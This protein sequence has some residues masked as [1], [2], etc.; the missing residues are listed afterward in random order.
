[1]L[2]TA[3]CV[4]A[5]LTAGITA[6]RLLDSPLRYDEADFGAQAKG[7]LAYGVPKVNENGSIR[8]GMWHPPLYLY[9]LAASARLFGPTDWALRIVGVGWFAGTAFL[10][11]RVAGALSLYLLLLAPIVA[12]GI[13]YLDIDNTSLSFALMLFAVTFTGSARPHTALTCALL[14]ATIF[15]ALWSKLTT[16]YIMLIAAAVFHT[17]N[18]DW[19]G[20][21]QIVAIGITATAAFLASYFLYCWLTGYP[22]SFMFDTTYVGK[23]DSYLSGGRSVIR[24][25]H[26]VWWNIIWFSPALS[27]L[28]ALF[29]VDRVRAFWSV[30]R[31][32]PIDLW[33]IFSGVCFGA[34]AVWAGVMGKYTFPAAL[35]AGVA[36]GLWIPGAISSVRLNRP[37]L[38]GLSVVGL[39]LFHTLAVPPL[40]VKPPL[41]EHA[42]TLASGLTDPR[43]VALCIVVASF[44]AFTALAV[45]AMSG[46]VLGRLV[47]ALLACSMVASTVEA[48]NVMLS[49][50]DRSP[51]RPFLECCF[52]PTVET[53][54][55]ALTPTDTIIAPKDIGYYF[56]GRSYRLDAARYTSQ[57]M[58]G[59]VETIRQAGIRHA[60]DS[61]ANPVQDSDRIFREAGLAPV[62]HVGDFVIYGPSR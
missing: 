55:R 57:G 2:L 51:Y 32:E 29:T 47:V 33:L 46:L 49:P 26:A 11:W 40:Q 37:F 13:F 43:T 24:S 12:Q 16:P 6:W 28:L 21:L 14:S 56:H 5:A 22:A 35:T 7:I 19:R 54:N 36:L 38:M 62:E 27:L 34:Y 8:Y 15:F 42:L 9:S 30:R 25:F 39:A 52:A 20:V 10:L 41:S 18:R 17:L 44:M 31:A 60:V 53:L 48:F 3:L 61:S 50:D 1:M 45:R 4:A 58:T 23:S 59:A